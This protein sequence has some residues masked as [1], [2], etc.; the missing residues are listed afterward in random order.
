MGLFRYNSDD[1]RVYNLRA[2]GA[3]KLFPWLEVNNNVDY[4]NRFYHNSHQR[5]RRWRYLA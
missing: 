3:I 5:R 4:S 1:F 2:K